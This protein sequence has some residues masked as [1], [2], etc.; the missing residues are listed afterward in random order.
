MKRLLAA[1]LVASLALPVSGQIIIRRSAVVDDYSDILFWLNAEA[2]E[3]ATCTHT[4]TLHA[5]KEHPASMAS[6]GSNSGWQMN[7]TAAK[8]GTR[9]MDQGSGVERLTFAITSND[10]VNPTQGRICMQFEIES[11][12][13][14]GHRFLFVDGT[15][16]LILTVHTGG[17]DVAISWADGSTDLCSTS[18]WSGIAVGTTY[19]LEFAYDAPADRLDVYVDGVNRGNSCGPASKTMDA[20]SGLA[21]LVVGGN[22]TSTGTIFTDTLVISDDPDRDCWALICNS[23]AGCASGTKDYPG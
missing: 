3:S 19:L 18:T 20:L 10:I 22:A 4:Y 7:A 2:C 1:L 21:T 12:A 5:T 6:S 15:T 11:A 14:A 17:D 13:D 23:T 16:D 8:A 9:G